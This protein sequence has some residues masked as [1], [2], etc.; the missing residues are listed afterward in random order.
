MIKS[1]RK[2]AEMKSKKHAFKAHSKLAH[3]KQTAGHRESY[4]AIAE[5]TLG[6]E[7]S[8]GKVSFAIWRKLVAA[9][10]LFFVTVDDDILGF[11]AVAI[12]RASL[13]R[14]TVALFLRAGKCFSHGLIYKVKRVIFRALRRLPGLTILSITPHAIQPQLAEVTNGWVYDPQYWDQLGRSPEITDLSRELVSEARGRPMLTFVGSVSKHKGFSYFCDLARKDSG[15]FF[16]AAGKVS[17]ECR[18]IFEGADLSHVKVVD[19]YL[20]DGEVESLFPVSKFIWCCYSPEYNQASG[21]F[22]RAL[23]FGKIPVVRAGSEIE[24]YAEAWAVPAIALEYGSPKEIE[25][26]TRFA[27]ARDNPLLPIS[28]WREEFIHKI[29]LGLGR[30]A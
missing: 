20:S 6:L 17:D 7:R 11:V 16:V 2:L 18:E 8:I 3:A 12:A 22:G 21:V 25:K 19:R 15:V 27:A 26:V 5:S 13:G 28:T 14:R 23:Q 24:S 1:E 4:I 29:H 30:D 9:D 10:E